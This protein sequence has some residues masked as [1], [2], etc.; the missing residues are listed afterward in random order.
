MNKKVH[1]IGINGSGASGAAIAAKKSGFDVSGCTNNME[2]PY[3]AQL[4]D[5]QIPIVCGHDASHIADADIVVAVS[6]ID[7]AETRAAAATGKLMTWQEFIAKYIFPGKRVIAVAGTHGK[8]TT[9][10]MLAHV[11]IAAGYDPTCFIGAI[12][13][14]WNSSNRFGASDWVVIEADEYANNFA[15][16]HPEFIILNN[17]EMEHP[18]FFTDFDHYKQTFRDFLAGAVPG[19]ALIYNA[20]DAGVM[21]VI[22]AF[23]GEKIPFSATD[24]APKLNIIGAHNIMNARG[25]FACAHRIG[26]K[27]PNLE[28]FR[29]AG[30]R[31][32]KIFSSRPITIYDDYAHHHAQA[33]TT[34]AAVRAAHPNARLIV[35]Y[36][37]HQISRW[38]QNTN[39]TIS[40]LAAADMAVVV[41]F[42]RGREL[43][44]NTPDAAKQIAASGAKNVQYIP[45]FD[46]ATTAIMTAARRHSPLEGESQ[47]ELVRD[48][49]R[50]QETVILVLGAGKSWV[51]A[52][53]IRDKIR[54]AIVG[55]GKSGAAAERFLRT[56]GITDITLFD[57]KTARP[58]SE[59]TDE[60][61]LVVQSPGI[62]PEK[63][64][65]ARGTSEIELGLT[66][67]TGPVIAITGTDGKSTTT[68][69]TA[70][71]LRAGG[72]SAIEC[73]N[74]GYP[75]CDAV[76]D[77]APGTI[78]V[79]EL[80]SYQ[81]DLLPS[82]KYFDAAALMNI[83]PDHLD[84]YKTMENYVASK[85]RIKNMVKDGG[86]F[87]DPTSSFILHPS[88]LPGKHNAR[89]LGYAVALAT[90]IVPDLKIDTSDLRGL[91]HRLEIVPTD[92][93]I[94]WVNDSKGTTIQAVQCALNAFDDNI[95]L[96]LGG[97]DK[98]LDFTELAAPIAK[99]CRA[100]IPFGAARD[101]IA[102]QL[103]PSLAEG[104]VALVGAPG[105]GQEC[106]SEISKPS[107][108]S[109]IALCGPSAPGPGENE[110]FARV[111]REG[112][113]DA[114]AAA[115]KIARPGDTVLL[116]PGCTSWDEFK[117]FEERGDRF[118][119]LVKK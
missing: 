49:V 104:P 10:A 71:I 89:N 34:I 35:A 70:Q 115:K 22:D 91:P 5:A 50:G 53:K 113:A 25:V 26:I 93:G 57:D 72:A 111:G 9:S 15:P 2:T 67:V 102:T 68:T 78:F 17:L 65:T 80:S 76:L 14:E 66:A 82:G 21:S 20:D 119:E 23:A 11:M 108:A 3:T 51:L 45:D 116:S 6:S 8:T 59:F 1:F 18:E 107:P 99:K 75:L 112:L 32:E 46:D 61:D 69:F 7:N 43:H 74:F 16:Y 81:L 30:H 44:L 4:I 36:E 47:S 12:V 88:S 39:A 37:P 87:F 31:L 100:V 52:K 41:E 38:E 48:A 97:Q 40:A 13:P 95:I 58:I 86:K 105:E 117:S 96:L 85:W 73:G 92:D 63:I 79:L 60:F 28:N 114:I 42:W 64:K 55:G 33:A 90:A 19:G 109:R 29:G 118:R 83:A 110:V 103:G 98:D 62:N 27:N 54:A 94:R 101:K 56:R 106:T 24:P 77:S 84:R